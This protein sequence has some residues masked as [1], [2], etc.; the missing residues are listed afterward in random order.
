[1]NLSS[2]LYSLFSVTT[3]PFLGA[4]VA[5]N[6]RQNN[7]SLTLTL[8]LQYY[9]SSQMHWNEHLLQFLAKFCSMLDTRLGGNVF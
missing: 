7:N 8:T 3:I 1:M 9:A 5:L 6:S 4:G 2:V